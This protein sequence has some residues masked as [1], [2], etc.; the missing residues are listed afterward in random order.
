MIRS[1]CLCRIQKKKN[2]AGNVWTTKH[3]DA[4]AKYSY[5][6]GH[7]KKIWYRITRRQRFGRLMPPASTQRTKF[8]VKWSIF[9]QI[10]IKFRFSRHIF[11]KVSDIKRHGNSSGERRAVTCRW[12]DRQTD[13]Q[14]DR[15]TYVTKVTGSF[16]D[17]AKE[18][19][20]KMEF[21]HTHSFLEILCDK[22]EWIRLETKFLLKNLWSKIYS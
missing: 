10:V 22:Q 5:P 6:I 12:K 2:K 7:P 1:F 13:R 16:G 15:R 20:N 18:R 19:K 21:T 9:F 14:T 8:H 17:C 4:F 11:A 3:G